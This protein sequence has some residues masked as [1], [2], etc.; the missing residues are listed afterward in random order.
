MKIHS[1]VPHSREIVFGKMNSCIRSG[2]KMP[3]QNNLGFYISISQ[4]NFLDHLL[5]NQFLHFSK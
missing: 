2:N 3:F 5:V 4:T 1:S